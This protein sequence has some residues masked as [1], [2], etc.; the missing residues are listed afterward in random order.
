MPLAALLC[1]LCVPIAGCGGSATATAPKVEVS[2][3]APTDGATVIVSRIEVLGTVAP[4]NAVLRVSGRHVRVRHG[5][6]DTGISLRRGLTHIRIEARAAG[7]LSSS[8]VISVRYA[9][10]RSTPAGSLG[11]AAAPSPA[12]VP[13]RG[14]GQGG[15]DI[16]PAARAEAISRC[17][18]GNGGGTAL[19]TCVFDRLDKAGFN[20]MAQWQALVEQWRQSLLSSGVIRYPR[21]MKGAIIACA[22]QFGG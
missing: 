6:F 15:G 22:R 7:F 13:S 11:G 21:V 3:S 20:T 12:S 5:A 10:R 19:C 9:P 2:L 4:D 1:A 17:S 8:T 14:G 18:D 16:P